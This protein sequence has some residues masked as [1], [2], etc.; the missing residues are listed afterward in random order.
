MRASEKRKAQQQRNIDAKAV[1]RREGVLIRKGQAFANDQELKRLCVSIAM[2][3]VSLE[4]PLAPG[5]EGAKRLHARAEKV[6]LAFRALPAAQQIGAWKAGQ[7]YVKSGGNLSEFLNFGGMAH[8]G[9]G[10]AKLE[11]HPEQA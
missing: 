11:E 3:Q 9:G 4:A 8:G 1:K 5:L 10:Q 2:I 7:D 6:Y